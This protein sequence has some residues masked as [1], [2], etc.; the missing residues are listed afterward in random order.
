MADDLAIGYLKRSALIA[1]IQNESQFNRSRP[2]SK[3]FKRQGHGAEL[4]EVRVGTRYSDQV[5][6]TTMDGEG[7]PIKSGTFKVRQFV[8]AWIKVFAELTQKDAALF[9]AAEEAAQ[10]KDAGGQ[11]V[12]DRANERIRELG[13]DLDANLGTERE[14]L[15]VDALKGSVTATLQDGTTQSINYGLTALTPPSTK[16]DDAAATIQ[17]NFYG[18]I[19]EFKAN[20]PLGLPPTH[21]AYHP[22]LWKESFAKNTEWKDFRKSS[23][24]LAE[25]WLRF[26]LGGG[27]KIEANTEGYFTDPLFNLIPVAIDGTYRNLSGSIVNYW[28]YKDLTLFRMDEAMFEWGMTYGHAYN[29]RPDVNIAFEA[30]S[31]PDV[32][33]WKV[34]G[35]DNGLPIIKRPE[36]VQTL[37]VIA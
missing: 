19:D 14:R 3:M 5:R 16:W 23:P 22:K 11:A 17:Q 8:P 35:M 27:N 12:V 7:V 31:R 32:A 2:I 29:P 15:C 33:V 34:H 9:A 21:F 36:L 1:A 10:S 20:N 28:D 25:A 26:V 24:A 18:A 37:R 30:P 6:H 13:A 4:V